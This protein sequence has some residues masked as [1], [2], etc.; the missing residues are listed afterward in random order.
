MRVRKLQHSSWIVM[1]VA[2]YSLTNTRCKNML[3]N[4]TWLNSIHAQNVVLNS[5]NIIY[6]VHIKLFTLDPYL[7]AVPSVPSLLYTSLS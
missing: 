1:S 3:R 4:S 5:I 6:Y 2:G 7:G